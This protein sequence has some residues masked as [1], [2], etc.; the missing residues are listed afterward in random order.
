MSTRNVGIA[1]G[2]TSLLVAMIA[3]LSRPA[4]AQDS[5]SPLAPPLPSFAP[6]PSVSPVA[7]PPLVPS[8]AVS[9]VTPRPLSSKERLK[10]QSIEQLAEHLAS[11]RAEEKETLAVLKEK[12]REQS[13]KLQRL[14]IEPDVAPTVTETR[15][16]KPLPA[17]TVPQGAELPR[18]SAADLPVAPQLGSS[19]KGPPS[20]RR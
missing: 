19:P 1:C 8:P 15:P 4:G 9:P 5:P 14:G 11:L 13:T 6:S 18:S 2:L 17:N 7:P 3:V 10:S 16:D 20:D 12:L